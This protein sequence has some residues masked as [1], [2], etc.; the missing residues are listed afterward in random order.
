MLISSF[1]VVKAEG[2]YK[3]PGCQPH[4]EAKVAQ[5]LST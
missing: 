4:G 5:L 1:D 2:R 3:W